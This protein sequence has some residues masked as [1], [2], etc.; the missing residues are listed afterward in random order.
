MIHS[1]G[2]LVETVT[3]LSAR[4]FDVL[5]SLPNCMPSPAVLAEKERN[6][7]EKNLKHKHFV[8]RFINQF[9]LKETVQD[10]VKWRLRSVNFALL[11]G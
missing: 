4:E 2:A 7:K 5:M 8:I 3:F 10:I 9:N 1:K 6:E 11:K